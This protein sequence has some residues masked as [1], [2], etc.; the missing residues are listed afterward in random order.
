MSWLKTCEDIHLK[1]KYG[2][3]KAQLNHKFLKYI[4]LIGYSFELKICLLRLIPFPRVTVISLKRTAVPKTDSFH[5]ADWIEWIISTVS[6]TQLRCII[7]LESF[8]LKNSPGCQQVRN[9][10]SSFVCVN[11]DRQNSLETLIFHN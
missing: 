9:D 5:I 7:E 6:G 11:S 3:Q 4:V 8:G 2:P 1:G 10:R